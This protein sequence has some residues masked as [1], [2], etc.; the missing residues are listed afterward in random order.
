MNDIG[1]EIRSH[2]TAW[3]QIDVRPKFQL[4]G[5]FFFSNTYVT[6]SDVVSKPQ[7]CWFPP[8]DLLVRITLLLTSIMMSDTFVSSVLV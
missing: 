1:P 7:K 5:I 2:H 8:T 6:M 3:L 4:S